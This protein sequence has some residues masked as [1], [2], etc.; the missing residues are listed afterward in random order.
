MATLPLS[1]VVAQQALTALAAPVAAWESVGLVGSGADVELVALV[2]G[3]WP[4][5][6]MGRAVDVVMR[7]D[8]GADDVWVTMRDAP[9][10]VPAEADGCVR[11]AP[12]ESLSLPLYGTG[13][14]LAPL[15]HVYGA[16]GAPEVRILATAAA[17]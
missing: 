4:V 14:G 17:A 5:A 6:A 7:N 8:S 10:A 15:M 12:G 1:S 13:R 3:A 9:P 16:A 11:I 2:D